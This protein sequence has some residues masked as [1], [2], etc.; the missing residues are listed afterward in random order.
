MSQNDIELV[1]LTIAEAK[2]IVERGKMAERLSHNPDFK[3]LVLD[4]YFVDEAARLVHL[5]CDPALPE[6][7][8]NVV[9]RDM[10]GPAAF[11]RYMS[12]MVQMGRNAA[13]E[14]L[15]HE[16]TLEELREEEFHD[17]DDGALESGE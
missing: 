7:M 16:E 5:S 3:K 9:V 11:K 17:G 4:G 8:R 6:N 2:K 1:E 12:A 14:I 13:R 15:E 10:A